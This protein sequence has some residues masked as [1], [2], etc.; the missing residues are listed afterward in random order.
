MLIILL[1][2]ST[3]PLRPLITLGCSGKLVKAACW[4]RSWETIAALPPTAV[5]TP[6]L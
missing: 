2:R 1:Y 4:R 6:G 3:A 5:A